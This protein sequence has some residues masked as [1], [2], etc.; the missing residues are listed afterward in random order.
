MQ[1]HTSVLWA[2]LGMLARTGQARAAPTVTLDN[3]T[4][5]GVV[6]GRTNQFLGIPFAQPP[7]VD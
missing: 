5:T 7:Y 4:V 3:A 6:L 2:I 1:L